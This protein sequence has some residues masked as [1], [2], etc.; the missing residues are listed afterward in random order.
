MLLVNH[1]LELSLEDIWIGIQVP[2]VE[3]GR[4]IIR[5]EQFLNMIAQNVY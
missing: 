1:K 3:C 5:L 4:Y 2:F